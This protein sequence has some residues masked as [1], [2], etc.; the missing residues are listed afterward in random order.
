MSRLFSLDSPVMNFLSNLADM[1]LLNI[2]YLICCIPII[3]IGAATTALYTVT[4]KM[5]RK[6]YPA[7]LK[8]F[9]TAFR[10]NL[11]TSTLCWIPMIVAAIILFLDYRLLGAL[12]GTLQS[13]I[14][15]ALSIIAL[16]YLMILLYLF[17]YIARFDNNVK[18]TFKN[19]LLISI[20]N[21]P[22]TLLMLVANITLIIVS[23]LTFQTMIIALSAAIL[24]T[25]SVLAYLQSILFTR[26]FKKYEP[27]ETESTED[28][29]ST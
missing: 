7:I 20:M 28:P 14:R 27:E 19:T 5:V 21:L 9:F 29:Q 26:I 23:L 8:S 25:F 16:L 24:I 4:L 6:E 18:N 2:V 10:K 13:V 3:T 17:P 11:K 15:I 22:L 1:I 12:P